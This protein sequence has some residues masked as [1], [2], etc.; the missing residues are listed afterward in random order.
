MGS[1]SVCLSVIDLIGLTRKHILKC[2]TEGMFH[3]KI[4]CSMQVTNNALAF[5][6]CKV[7][8]N[9]KTLYK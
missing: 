9:K 2:L 6:I 3:N 8:C 4:N 5:G 7:E 1:F